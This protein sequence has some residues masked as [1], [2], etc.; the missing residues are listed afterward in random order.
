M[1]MELDQKIEK[2]EGGGKEALGITDEYIP[3]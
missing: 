2:F 3:F 1:K